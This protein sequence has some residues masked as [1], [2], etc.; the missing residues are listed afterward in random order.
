MTRYKSWISASASRTEHPSGILMTLSQEELGLAA[1][2]LQKLEKQVCFDAF[3]PGSRPTSFQQ[4][5]IDD[6]GKVEYQYV[7]AAN[8]SGKTQLGARIMAWMLAEDMPNWSRPARWGTAPLLFLVI[9]RVSKQVEEAI[10]RKIKGFFDEGEVHETRIGNALQKVTHRRTGNCIIFAS[11]HNAAEAREKVQA[12]ELAGIL[13]DEMPSS[14]LLF[15]ELQRRVQDKRG[16]LLATFTPKT[17]NLEIRKLVEGGRAPVAKQYKL[18]MFDNPVY[19]DDDKAQILAS[20]ENM[21]AAYRQC[22]LEGDWMDDDSAVYHL[23]EGAIAERPASYSLTWRHVEGA[24]PALQSKH[25]QVVFA[26]DPSTGFWYCTIA[27]YIQ[28][29]VVPTELVA[30]VTGRLKHFNVVRRVCD[31]ASTWYIGQAQAD[32][33]NYTTPWD[34]N[35][36]RAEM[37]KN[38]QTALGTKVFITPEALNLA[39]ELGAMQWSETADARVVNSHSYHLHDAAIYAFDCLPKREGAS[40]PIPEL[41]VRLRLQMERDRKAAANREKARAKSRITQRPIMRIGRSNK[42]WR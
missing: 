20:L 35:N 31:S 23:P 13:L 11:H 39:H 3:K 28:G 32:G 34:K 5:V 9:G 6:F 10:W 27:D 25:G 26:E 14:V 21:P 18:R 33:F 42:A 4:Q 7:V 41:H 24:D 38:F 16:F 40:A 29:I 8:R 1:A 22:V 2:R 15:E 17:K 30:A 36:R 19:T 12:Y 37:M